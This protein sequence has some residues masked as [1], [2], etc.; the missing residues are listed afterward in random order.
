ME[1]IAVYPGSF[2]P[3]T[4][5]H[6]DIIKRA[7]TDYDVVY[8]AVMVNSEKQYT[9]TMDERVE[10]A[11]AALSDIENVCVISSEGMLW[12]LA[13]DLSAEAIVKGYRNDIDLEYELKMAAYNETKN[14]KAKTVLLRSKQELEKV[15]STEAR[16]RLN[17]NESLSDFLPEPA[18]KTINNIL[19]N[20][21]AS[22]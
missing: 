9:F 22:F 4:N 8:V 17:N 2:D 13:E 14:P 18:I 11:I 21:H 3:I 15:S 7:S 1:K 20:K 16:K 12:K 10:I 6:L 19:K 5:G